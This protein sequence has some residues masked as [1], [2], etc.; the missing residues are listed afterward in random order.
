VMPT[1]R[2]WTFSRPELWS[3]HG[4]KDAYNPSFDTS[5]PSGWIGSE[6]LAIDQGPIVMMLENYRTGF[7]WS[8]NAKNK[9]LTDGLSRAGF[10]GAWLPN[11]P[12][13]VP[14]PGTLPVPGKALPLVPTQYKAPTPGSMQPP[15]RTP[16]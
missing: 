9:V 3:D 11:P 16:R 2:H 12:A 15:C 4:F 10:A 8:L 6:T 7:F 5:K 14:T 13:T 1:L